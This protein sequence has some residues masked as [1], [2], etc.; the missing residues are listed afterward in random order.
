MKAI[1]SNLNS[2]NHHDII[3]MDNYFS[4]LLMWPHVYKTQAF[5]FS[6]E[7]QGEQVEFY[8]FELDSNS[9]TSSASTFK[10]NSK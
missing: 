3:L 8:S 4:S 5:V 7:N 6:F 9:I 2:N 10:V 1:L